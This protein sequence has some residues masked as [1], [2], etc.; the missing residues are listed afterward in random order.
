MRAGCAIALSSCRSASYCRFGS[1][2][3]REIRPR[4][5]SPRHDGIVR[6]SAGR[7]C[8]TR[9]TPGRPARVL[10][11]GSSIP[12]LPRSHRSSS[13]VS[14]WIPPRARPA[15]GADRSGASP[16]GTRPSRSFMLRR[17]SA[18]SASRLALHP[19]EIRCRATAAMRDAVDT[20][21]YGPHPECVKADR[22]RF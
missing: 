13:I 20:A 14:R 16:H 1:M 8:N 15:H 4:L 2:R 11:E 6:R 9:A 22:R 5:R 18:S 19:H 10:V 17:R 7:R 12:P 21:A 3:Q